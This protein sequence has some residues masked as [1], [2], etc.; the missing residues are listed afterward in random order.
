MAHQDPNAAVTDLADR[1]WEGVLERDP[2]TATI[3][4]DDRYD[5]RWPDLGPDGRAAE[6]SALASALAEAETMDPAGLDV[7]SGITRDL[8]ML[9]ARNYLEALDRRLY[10]LAVNH[11]SGVQTW[12]SEIAQYQRAETPEGLRRL[13]AR[14]EAFPQLID[15]H[16]GTLDEGIGDHRTSASVPVQKAVEQI[17]RM[18]AVPSHDAPSVTL[19]NV[20]DEPARDDVR[21]AV[22][23][24]IYPALQRLRDYLAKTYTPHAAPTPAL[25]DT[26]DGAA[27]YRLAIRMQTTVDATPDEVHAF[28]LEDLERIEAEKDEIGRRQ[29]HADRHAY[30]AA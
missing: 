2:I 25:G 16:I 14:F 26:P 23:A 5:D 12:P 1:F 19:A 29:G 6:R 27:A 13:L 24:H 9:V 21:T 18:L 15:Q 8:L 28:G 11:M 10:Q 22:A 3:Y 17:D 30:A 7:E 4:G 20:A